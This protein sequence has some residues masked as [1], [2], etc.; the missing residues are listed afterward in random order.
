MQ[1]LV[2]LVLFL[3]KWNPTQINSWSRTFRVGEPLLISFAKALISKGY[4]YSAQTINN[5]AQ[6]C[7][8]SS[9]QILLTREGRT[10]VKESPIGKEVRTVE[11]SG[12][13]GNPTTAVLPEYRRKSKSGTKK[14]QLGFLPPKQWST[15]IRLNWI[16]RRG[17][18]FLWRVSEWFPTK[19][20][21]ALTQ[22]SSK[23]SN[24]TQHNTTEEEHC[25]DLVRTVNNCL[26]QTTIV[27]G[28][29]SFSLNPCSSIFSRARSTKLK[30]AEIVV[31]I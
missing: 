10:V 13:T 22:Q 17:E 25:L 6:L 16:R 27:Q 12:T 18:D 23:W 26:V 4:C 8:W 3:I 20:K 28:L 30:L 24:T 5:P 2:L 21:S 11:W 7:K 14:V 19:S 1:F 31:L 15:F 29:P 9:W